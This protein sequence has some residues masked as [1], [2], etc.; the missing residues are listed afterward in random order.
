MIYSERTLSLTYYYVVSR[1]SFDVNIGFRADTFTAC[2]KAW[3]VWTEGLLLFS[4]SPC[5]L[6]TYVTGCGRHFWRSYLGVYRWTLEEWYRFDAGLS[7]AVD[8]DKDIVYCCPDIVV[9]AFWVRRC[10]LDGVKKIVFD[11][12]FWGGE[13]GRICWF[14]EEARCSLEMVATGDSS[15][16]KLLNEGATF[17]EGT[18]RATVLMLLELESFKIRLWLLLEDSTL[19]YYGFEISSKAL[20]WEGK[21]D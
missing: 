21:F 4:C 18:V 17:Y 1:F 12:G 9:A 14:G 2:C 7:K 10:L 16:G 20:I 15:E 3:L 6:R 13:D 8:W 5:T 19:S 11:V